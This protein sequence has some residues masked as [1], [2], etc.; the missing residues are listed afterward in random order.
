[1]VDPSEPWPYY[2]PVVEQRN[3]IPYGRILI[4]SNDIRVHQQ[5]WQ[6]VDV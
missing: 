3:N 4:Q 2:R 1:M 5:H 6:Y